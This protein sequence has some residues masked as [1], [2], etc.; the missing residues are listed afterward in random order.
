MHPQACTRIAS[1]TIL[2]MALTTLGLVAALFVTATP[3]RTSALVPSFAG[4]AA[5]K[6]GPTD[7]QR[8]TLRVGEIA[9]NLE[10][11]RHP[12]QPM[13]TNGG[14]VANEIL[15]QLPAQQQRIALAPLTID[16]WNAAERYFAVSGD[17]PGQ[18]VASAL[19]KVPHD[20]TGAA[21]HALA[22]A[23]PTVWVHR[24][25]YVQD[26]ATGACTM[27]G[28]DSTVAYQATIPQ[29]TS[30]S[31][32]S[33][34]LLAWWKAV[35]EHIRQHEGHHIRIFTDFVNALPARVANQP[36]SSWDAIIAKWSADIVSAQ[37]AFDV[38]DAGWAYPVYT[39]S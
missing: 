9:L 33:P 38:I 35:L 8:P 36:C 4:K 16:V 27:T 25:S 12:A 28:V 14:L 34:A 13:G 6:L 11:T 18:I 32:V 5:A 37:M 31:A 39:G 10:P 19:T 17:S 26:V 24:P 2:L 7:A 21:R 1:G 3:D 22:Y 20:P 23:G 30:P 15:P 29:W